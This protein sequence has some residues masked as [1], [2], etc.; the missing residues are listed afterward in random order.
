MRIQLLVVEKF[1]FFFLHLTKT[2]ERREQRFHIFVSWK[3]GRWIAKF[4][5]DETDT[6]EACAKWVPHKL[7]ADHKEK[8][9][10]LS[11]ATAGST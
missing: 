5:G 3:N 10:E 9:V 8:R 2:I 6:Q 4:K 7:T 11:K 1:Y